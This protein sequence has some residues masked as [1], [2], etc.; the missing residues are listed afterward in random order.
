MGVTAGFRAWTDDYSNIVRI[1]K[2]LPSWL[3]SALP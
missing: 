2:D 1:T 3:R